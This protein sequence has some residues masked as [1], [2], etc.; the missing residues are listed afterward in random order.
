MTHYVLREWGRLPIGDGAGEVTPTQASSLAAAAQQSAFARRDGGG[1]LDYGRQ[2]LC[3]RGVVGIVAG[4]GCSLEILP[5]IDALETDGAL[6]DRLVHMLDVAFDLKIDLGGTSRTQWQSETLLDVLI[7][8]FCEKLAN[9]LRKGMPRAY[10]TLEDDLPALR[11]GLNVTRQFTRHAVNPSRLAC[12]FDEF[13][14]DIA[15]NQIMKVTV[16]HLSHHAR[17]FAVQ[18][19]LRELA[20]LYAEIS[21]VPVAM[22]PWDRVRLDR[23]N[24]RWQGLLALSRLFLEQKFQSTTLGAGQGAALLFNMAA[25]FENYIGRL[26][27][28]ACAGTA[29]DVR[30]Q[31]GRKYCLTDQATGRQLFQTKPDIIIRRNGVVTHIIDTKWK[32]IEAQIDDSKRG[33]S[34]ADVYQMMAYS[35]LYKAPRLTLLYPQSNAQSERD[36]VHAS[37]DIGDLATLEIASV[38]LDQSVADIRGQLARIVEGGKTSVSLATSH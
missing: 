27:R 11:G 5:K 18:Q 25:L 37:F 29:L 16:L 23:T 34:Q 32:Q 3:A 14:P 6:R 15:L 36:G 35:Q 30:L 13:L 4:E 28:R 22:L 17:S 2:Y 31:G 9:A 7:R 24:D 20:F 19:E 26:T 21:D 38:A 1:V 10:S 33:V 12:R 8:A